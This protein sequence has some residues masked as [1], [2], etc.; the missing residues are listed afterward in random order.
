MSLDWYDCGPLSEAL[1]AAGMPE[2]VLEW[3]TTDST[4]DS[5]KH[6][7][8]DEHAFYVD[9]ENTSEGYWIQ[10]SCSY[11]NGI[12]SAYSDGKRY[13]RAEVEKMVKVWE[14]SEVPQ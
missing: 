7:C 11:N 4:K 9:P 12:Q 6:D 10:T 1:K 2:D 13:A 8:T 14:Y 5:G 3:D